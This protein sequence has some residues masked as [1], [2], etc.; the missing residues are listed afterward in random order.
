MKMLVTALYEHV[1]YH[2]EKRRKKK[3]WDDFNIAIMIF[4]FKIKKVTK[5]E[6]GDARSQ[7]N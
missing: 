6:V 3:M 7:I 4:Q 1:K 2:T 5:L